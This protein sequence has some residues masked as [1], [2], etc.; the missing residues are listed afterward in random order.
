MKILVLGGSGFIGTNIVLKLSENDFNEITI[1]DKT[2]NS[3][4]ATKKAQLQRVSFINSFRAI[5]KNRL[6][7]CTA[8]RF[9]NY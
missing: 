1:V 5:R 6:R 7:Y 3:F 2:K 8:D 9:P 4:E